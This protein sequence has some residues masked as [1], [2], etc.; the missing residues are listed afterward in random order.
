M[1]EFPEGFDAEL[2]CGYQFHFFFGETIRGF[3]PVGD[4]VFF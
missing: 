4:F 3:L 2:F 1:R